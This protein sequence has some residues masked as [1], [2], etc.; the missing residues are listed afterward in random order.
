MF[1]GGH[2]CNPGS[3]GAS[4]AAHGQLRAGGPS[5]ALALH[6]TRCQMASDSLQA[7]PS[8][9]SFGGFGGLNISVQAWQGPRWGHHDS[10][11]C[12]HLLG[13]LQGLR[14]PHA[15]DP[16]P[17]PQVAACPHNALLGVGDAA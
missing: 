1:S 17:S 3:L 11:A 8:A 16:G 5:R 14:S 4:S 2:L 15:R 7:P 9:P 6:P 13:H 12:E 10:T